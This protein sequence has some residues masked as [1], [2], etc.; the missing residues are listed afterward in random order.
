[1]RG[2]Q[3]FREMRQHTNFPQN[4]IKIK[5][6]LFRRGDPPLDVVCSAQFEFE[7]QDTAS[8]KYLIQLVYQVETAPFSLAPLTLHGHI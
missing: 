8:S 4:C 1:M 6:M 7:F 3:P 2:R 5:K